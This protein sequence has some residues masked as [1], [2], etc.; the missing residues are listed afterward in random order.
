MLSAAAHSFRQKSRLAVGLSWVAGYT[1]VITVMMLGSVVVSH[2]TGNVTHVGLAAAGAVVGR[3]GAVGQLLFFGHVVLSFFAGAVASAVLIEWARRRGATARY[4]LPMAAEAALLASVAAGTALHLAGRLDAGSPLNQY[5]MTGAAAAAMGL[6]NATITRVSGAVVRTT[7]L[8]GVVTDLGLEGVQYLLWARG[9]GRRRRRA[10]L[11]GGDGAVHPARY[12]RAWRLSRRH[13]SFQRLALLAGIFGSFLCGAV[14][15]SLAFYAVPAAALLVPVA[16]LAGLIVRVWR[17]PVADVREVG[18]ATAGRDDDAG[19]EADVV[20]AGPVEGL[21][22]ALPPG[23]GLYQLS[24]RR[25]DADHHAPDFQA[26]LDRVPPRWRVVIL[27]VSPRT[28]FDADS[29]HDLAAAVRTLRARRRDLVLC[30]VCPA[31]YKVLARNGL[32]D[33]IGPANVTPDPE[34]AAARA[35]NLMAGSSRR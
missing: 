26:W 30:G 14:A 29:A 12:A 20:P 7:H 28:R 31:Q 33:A 11:A 5:W 9:R 10:G 23:V 6:Q 8:T 35:I 18:P 24:H 27:V 25:P 34:L 32:I 19:D 4:S 21:R 22:R 15:G 1:N 16:F 17:K 13:P 2:V 3:P